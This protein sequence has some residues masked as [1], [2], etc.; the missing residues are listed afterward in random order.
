MLKYHKNKIKIKKDSI[1]YFNIL[2]K[3][4]NFFKARYK[5]N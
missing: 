2:N 5:L 4:L 3:K 1:K